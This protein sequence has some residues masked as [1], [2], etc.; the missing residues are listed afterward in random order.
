MYNTQKI[1]FSIVTTYIM[2]SG[3]HKIYLFLL[4][5]TSNEQN[6][7]PQST[8][9]AEI[10]IKGKSL[11]PL[12]L[13]SRSRSQHRCRVPPSN[14]HRNSLEEPTGLSPVAGARGDPSP[15]LS[16][17]PAGTRPQHSAGLSPVTGARAEIR[18]P[19]SRRSLLL[20]VPSTPLVSTAT[21]SNLYLSA[22]PEYFRRL[23][24]S[25][26]SAAAPGRRDVL[27]IA[28]WQ[29]VSVQVASQQRL[30]PLLNGN[31]VSPSGL[32]PSPR[33]RPTGS[34]QEG[35][36]AAARARFTTSLRLA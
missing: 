35:T 36:P 27:P 11:A 6:P 22:S 33:S 4:K 29:K 26:A 34:S 17:E 14:G 13:W 8:D 15:Y 18:R 28:V 5:N 21:G 25:A 32:R 19:I 16:E 2:A 10:Y 7:R 12:R 23:S 30:L 20:L 3:I 31:T 24:S 9:Y 1:Y